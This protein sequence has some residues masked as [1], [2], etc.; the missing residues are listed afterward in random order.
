MQ[1]QQVL[2]QLGTAARWPVW[3]HGVLPSRTL[4]T[5]A[6]LR[7]EALLGASIGP[8]SGGHSGSEGQP[9]AP[10]LSGSPQAAQ[11]AGALWSRAF[12]NDAADAETRLAW[13]VAL[14]VGAATAPVACRCSLAA[15]AAVVAVGLSPMRSGPPGQLEHLTHEM[16]QRMLWHLRHDH[17]R[18]HLGFVDHAPTAPSGEAIEAQ[19]LERWQLHADDLWMLPGRRSGLNTGAGAASAVVEAQWLEYE[20]HFRPLVEAAPAGQ[21]LSRWRE[22]FDAAWQGGWNGVGVENHYMRLDDDLFRWAD[23][24]AQEV[25]AD[26]LQDWQAGRRSIHACGAFVAR[27]M[28]QIAGCGE[29]ADMLAERQRSQSAQCDRQLA[30]LQGRL[31]QPTAGLGG[32]SGWMGRRTSAAQ[33]QFDTDLRQAGI[34]L[35]ERAVALTRAAALAFAARYARALGS[36]LSDLIG[37]IDAV[38]LALGSLAGEFEQAAL[39]ALPPRLGDAADDPRQI[40]DH[41]RQQWLSDESSQLEHA[42]RTRALWFDLL[43]K[44]ANFRTFAL[45]LAEDHMR[46]P[47]LRYCAAAAQHHLEQMAPDLRQDLS[48]RW[49]ASP[50]QHQPALSQWAADARQGWPAATPGPMQACLMLPEGE[51]AD[52]AAEAADLAWAECLQQALSAQLHLGAA[53]ALSRHDIGGPHRPQTAWLVCLRCAAPATSAADSMAPAR[54]ADVTPTDALPGPNDVRPQDLQPAAAA[55]RLLL[56]AAALSVVQ[57]RA[58]PQDGGREWLLLRRDSDGF[59]VERSVL[60]RDLDG[61]A[62]DLTPETMARLRAAIAELDLEHLL[63]DPARHTP[64]RDT[65][66]E[67][68]ESLRAAAAPA[69]MDALSLAWSE[70]ARA[71]M[72]FARKEAPL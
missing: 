39:A 55:R 24:K 56:L 12:V 43:G 68:L 16:A 52:A 61:V 65:L 28:E 45:E 36:R 35:R 5:Q 69:Q 64:L 27:L 6:R 25:E 58:S 59:D 17:W 13:W 22:L 63:H 41:L 19:Q 44:R 15:E 66:R 48:L 9:N 37:L 7:A 21:R 14:Q 20:A 26:L 49:Q 57:E 38:E 62:G 11:G 8:D 10:A 33:L 30:D 31:T 18:A 34:A 1:L 40:L 51:A 60:G 72:R 54:P 23:L 42:R 46:H 71:V 53:D 70:A 47:L 50:A 29:E 67:Q 3:L 2:Q 32:L 4:Q